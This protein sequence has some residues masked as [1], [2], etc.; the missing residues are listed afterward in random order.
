MIML[1]S[2]NKKIEA[3]NK[4]VHVTLVRKTLFKYK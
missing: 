4:T 3:N 2:L 1:Y